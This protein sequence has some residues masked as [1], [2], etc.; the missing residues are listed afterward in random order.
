MTCLVDGEHQ[1]Q[2]LVLEQVL[3]LGRGP[4]ELGLV[5]DGVLEGLA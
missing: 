3:D 4:L 1:R 5:V 2:A